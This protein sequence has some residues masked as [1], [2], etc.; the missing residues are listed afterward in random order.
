MLE[1]RSVVV[2]VVAAALGCGKP[3]PQPA[4]VAAP[5]AAVAHD[6]NAVAVADAAAGRDDIAVELVATDEAFCARA[7]SG[8][9][10]CW[11]AGA[12]GELGN[13]ATDASLAPVQAHGIEHATKLAATGNRVCAV[14]DG[15]VLCW[16][17]D[18]HEKDGSNY[19]QTTPQ[20]IGDDKDVVDLA[21]GFPHVCMIHR[22]R[23][24]TCR[25]VY[26]KLDPAA[27]AYPVAGPVSAI[28]GDAKDQFEVTTPNGAIRVRHS[29]IAS[30]AY[31][32]SSENVPAS[33]K[34]HSASDAVRNEE[35]SCRLAKDGSISC[36]DRKVAIGAPPP[37]VPDGTLAPELA[38]PD[39]ALVDAKLDEHGELSLCL[40]L[41]RHRF[42]WVYT[43]RQ[44][45]AL[46]GGVL[47]AIAAWTKTTPDPPALGS[48]W[49]DAYVSLAPS[50]RAAAATI[51]HDDKPVRDIG[52][53]DLTGATPK[54]VWKRSV[55]AH[56]TEAIL[57]TNDFVAH[58]VSDTMSGPLSLDLYSRSGKQLRLGPQ[59]SLREKDNGL[60][61]GFSQASPDHVATWSP[62]VRLH[63]L[64]DPDERT[65]WKLPNA[66]HVL[67]VFYDEQQHLLYAISEEPLGEVTV[68]DRK[69][70][71]V[72][73]RTALTRP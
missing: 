8:K 1:R 73:T 66:K 31:V 50:G 19:G 39:A 38:L 62:D 36:G 2:F 32:L 21:V 69:T 5:E 52:F 59:L 4:V 20:V 71:R 64:R 23:S 7:E 35:D 43:N 11:G 51:F 63:S 17:A 56:L 27:K 40:A 6:A 12:N 45:F 49:E 15:H 55:A 9:V 44:C 41:G 70:K 60:H 24:V 53:F 14:A 58:I 37:P 29:T 42:P 67:L 16:G 72:V 22:D 18:F 30:G 48:D 68:Y 47:R 34:P 61:G 3:A 10:F 65:G 57:M 54:L 28:R 25:A 46:V 26:P 33:A 13:G